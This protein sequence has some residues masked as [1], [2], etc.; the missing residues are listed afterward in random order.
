MHWP[1]LE[2]LKIKYWK[3]NFQEFFELSMANAL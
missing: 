2:A 3:F 1:D